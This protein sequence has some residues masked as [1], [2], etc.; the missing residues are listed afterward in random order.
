[1]KVAILAPRGW[2]TGDASAIMGR[3]IASLPHMNETHYL[4]PLF[5]PRSVAVI[6]PC[7]DEASIAN[8]AVRNLRDGRFRGPI[9]VV[10]PDTSSAH[11]LPCVRSLSE[12]KGPID[13]AVI[14]T[15]IEEV[16]ALL[17]ECAAVGIR[18]AIL[19]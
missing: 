5:Q 15:P 12:A 19:P 14:G 13:L 2:V 18:A 7:F 16:P 10:A 1:A 8:I 9:T 4:A 6:G 17:A 11:G 3:C